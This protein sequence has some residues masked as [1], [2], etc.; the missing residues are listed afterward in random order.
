VD[1]IMTFISDD[2]CTPTRNQS[3]QSRSSTS[4]EFSRTTEAST[5]ER[6]PTVEGVDHTKLMKDAVRAVERLGAFTANADLTRAN[7]DLTRQLKHA[8]RDK[9]FGIEVIGN[10]EEHRAELLANNGKLKDYAAKLHADKEE[11]E[12]RIG[13]LMSEYSRLKVTNEQLG[14]KVTKLDEMRELLGS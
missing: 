6:S 4:S 11:L 12:Q 13:T 2:T 5:T 10:L 1:T 8:R 7:A 14:R 3:T 9:D